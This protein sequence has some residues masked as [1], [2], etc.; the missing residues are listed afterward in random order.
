MNPPRFEFQRCP[1]C[2]KAG[3]HNKKV[4]K[5]TGSFRIKILYNNLMVLQCYKCLKTCACMRIGPLRDWGSMS[6][7]ERSAFKEEV[8][9]LTPKKSQL[10]KLKEVTK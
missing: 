6:T 1:Y 8:R 9:H 7:Q 4:S 10:T 3:A 2:G 5:S